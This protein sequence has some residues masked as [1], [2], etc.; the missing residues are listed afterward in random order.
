MIFNSFSKYGISRSFETIKLSS[1]NWGSILFS[2]SVWKVV[3]AWLELLILF[4]KLAASITFFFK[5]HDESFLVDNYN[6][7]NL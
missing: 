5:I 7:M 1:M 3:I 6:H 2:Y 4:F